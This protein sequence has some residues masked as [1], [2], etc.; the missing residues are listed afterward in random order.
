M[1]IYPV[2]YPA[3]SRTQTRVGAQPAAR[4]VL[5]STTITGAIADAG[6]GRSPRCNSL[7]QTPTTVLTLALA[8]ALAGLAASA[9][10]DANPSEAADPWLEVIVVTGAAPVSAQSFELDPKLP[11]Q[12]IPASDGAD[13]L[14]TI[15]GFNAIRSGGSNGDPVLR[16]LSG[17]RLNLQVGDGALV[18]ACPARM[19]NALSYVSPQTWDRV[20]VVKGPQTVLWGPVG[21]TGTV[22]FERDPPRFA[23]PGWQLE[24]SLVGGSRDRFDQVIDAAA[25][26]ARGYARL[27]GNHGEAADYRD[28][29][30]DLVPSRWRKWNTDLALGWTPDANTVIELSVGNGDG[31]ARYAGRG[32]DGSQFKRNS[33]GLR[34]Q[35]VNPGSTLAEI[36]AALFQHHV[37]HVMDNY[38]LR[39]PDP[40]G[41]MPMAMVHAVDQRSTG[42]RAALTWSWPQLELVTGIDQQDSRHRD[43]GGAGID[44]HLGQP[45]T[46]DALF[47]QYGAFA[48]ASLEGDGPGRWVAG[49]RLDRVRVRDLRSGSG[50]MPHASSGQ[51]RAESL[52]SGFLRYEHTPQQRPLG[53]NIGV[54][55]AARMPDYWELFSA[56]QGPDGS[57][58]AFLGLRP[59]RSTQLDMGLTWQRGNVEAWVSAY[60]GRIDN[61]I[62]FDYRQH[63]HDDDHGGGGDHGHGHSGHDGHDEHDDVG[64]DH[65]HG[66]GHGTATQA[67]NVNARVAGAELGVE[68]R[69]LPSLKLTGSL[70]HARGSNR[71][72]HQPLPQIAPLEARLAVE[73][74]RGDFSAGGLLRAVDSQT[75]SAPG[76]GNVVGQDLG[77]SSG[78]AVLSAN[79]AWRINGNWRAAAGIDN[80]FDRAY[81]EHLNLSGNSAFGYPAEPV[82]INEPGRSVW[83]SLDFSY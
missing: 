34:L 12:P 25:G 69:L 64:D 54:G 31:E 48:E 4:P 47:S 46:P 14:K 57:V 9:L 24:G 78:F 63:G 66:H 19:D 38:S 41:P 75:R 37:D 60:A 3:I 82:R 45:W 52:T 36:E 43:R 81:A 56:N 29:N 39:R 42:G 53:F 33:T 79:A 28:G 18:G 50:H 62:L 22:R 10:A 61:F 7:S 26:T 58:N 70:A 11:R 32:M 68:W 35:R 17:S 8:L 65:D 23:E 74:Q 1:T 30:G 40:H 80:L 2:N 20:T 55:H 77:D 71:D 67:R 73:W 51:R 59:E 44:A 5:P 6:A 15:P 21:I 76:F 16:G 49:G 27:S 72:D 83:L 13:Y